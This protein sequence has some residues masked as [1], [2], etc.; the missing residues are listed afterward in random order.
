MQKRSSVLREAW[1]LFWKQ[2]RDALVGLVG[3]LFAMLSAL[4]QTSP[5]PLIMR[6]LLVVAGLIAVKLFIDVLLAVPKVL[7]L[8]REKHLPL[9]VIAGKADDEYRAM[10]KDV[11]AVVAKRGFDEAVFRRDFGIERDDWVIRS[12]RQLSTDPGE[13]QELVGRVALRVKHLESQITGRKV[14]HV[15]LNCPVALAMGVGAAL[16]IKHEVVIYHFQKE[17]GTSPYTPLVDFYALNV[18]GLGGVSL[19]KDRVNGRYSFIRLEQP[20]ELTPDLY[21]S[22]HLAPTDPKESIKALAA[23]RDAA[24]VHIR[25]IRAGTLNLDADWLRVSREV[26]TALRSLLDR[27]DVTRLHVGLSCPVAVS[28]AVGMALGVQVPVTV[29]HW[30]SKQYHPLLAL[31]ALRDLG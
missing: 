16:G 22:V 24:A 23:E 30:Q 14:F 28:F 11:V 4:N 27:S 21:V 13:W 26:A 25:K 17:G 19:V 18:A 3:V 5:L 2:K 7:R 10:V 20:E 29:F 9:L 1:V 15:F 8:V 12:E 31:D 6:G